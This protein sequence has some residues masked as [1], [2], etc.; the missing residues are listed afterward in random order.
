[1]HRPRGAPEPARVSKDG[2]AGGGGERSGARLSTGLRNFSLCSSMESL[3]NL[4]RRC[5]VI[6]LG[7]EIEHE[8]SV[9]SDA[10]TSHDVRAAGSAGGTCPVS[11]PPPS[12]GARSRVTQEPYANASVPPPVH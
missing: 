10:V 1:M 5:A 3:E 8:A 12:N 9:G 7:C 2:A 6:C 4:E 11:R